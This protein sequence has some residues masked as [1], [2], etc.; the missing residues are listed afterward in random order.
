[1]S[2]FIKLNKQDVFVTSYTAYKSWV[3][4]SASFAEY[5]IDVLEAETGST[6]TLFD[7]SSASTTGTTKNQYKQLIHSSLDHLYYSGVY[8]GNTLTSSY[9]DYPQTTLYP[10]TSR[11]LGNRAL[12]VTIPQSIFG[13]A[14]RPGTFTL[15]NSVPILNY[16]SGGYVQI[17]YVTSGGIVDYNIY[18]NGEGVL[19]ESG[20]LRKVGD[21]IYSH[22][23]AIITDTGSIASIQSLTNCTP[24]VTTFSTSSYLIPG[25]LSGSYMTGSIAASTG[26]ATGSSE[27]GYNVGWQST[28]TIYTHNYKCTV[29]EQELNY[30]QNPS[31]KSGSNGD[32]YDFATGSYFQ[33]YATTVGLYND[34]NELIAVGKLSQPVPKSTY[35]DTTFIV[36]FDI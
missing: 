16:V 10:S 20:S 3:V 23:L 34:S 2:A 19:L 24:S 4:N 36:K 12:V 28:Y 14:I 26:S 1:M 6:G 7:P 8:T 30:S 25:Y 29:R 33:P 5:G 35:T 27:C 22:G 21:I 32:L 13:S 11:D 17:A 15:G 18:D 31:I 9:E